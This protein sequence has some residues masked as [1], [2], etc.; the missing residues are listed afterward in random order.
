M[1]FLFLNNLGENL[2]F[3]YCFSIY[4]WFFI[5]FIFCPVP[6]F[7]SIICYTS[8]QFRLNSFLTIQNIFE[9]LYVFV[10]LFCRVPCSF[11]RGVLK[12][13]ETSVHCFCSFP[14]LFSL[15]CFLRSMV[16]SRSSDASY[17]SV[18]SLI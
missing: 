14:S 7:I 11:V 5:R 1:C 15:F 17:S 2:Q 3:N 12:Q 4:I 18:Q 8:L 10:F 6:S 9:I 13:Q 16:K